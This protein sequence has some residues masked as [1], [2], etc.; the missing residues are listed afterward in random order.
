M[1]SNMPKTRMGKKLTIVFTANPPLC[2]EPQ[3]SA[4]PLLSTE[5][6]YLPT[7][8]KAEVFAFRFLF[9]EEGGET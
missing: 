3:I 4:N 1:K 9:G 2:H 6:M 5:G 8:Y 7:V